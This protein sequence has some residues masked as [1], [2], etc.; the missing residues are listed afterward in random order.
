MVVVVVVVVAVAVV[1]VVVVV[2]VC[3][4]GSALS[5]YDAGLEGRKGKYK[6]GMGQYIH[7]GV[8]RRR[9]RRP[10]P[11]SSA[12]HESKL[13]GTNWTTSERGKFIFYR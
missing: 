11:R 2:A 7:L 4:R 3:S 5:K 1:V 12:A 8:R 6:Q 10:A 9:R 13:G